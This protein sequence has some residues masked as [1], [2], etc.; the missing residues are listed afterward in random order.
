MVIPLNMAHSIYTLHLDF[1]KFTNYDS[2]VFYETLDDNRTISFII[3]NDFL[4]CKK[5]EVCN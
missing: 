1:N 3:H 4:F 5:Q 2:N